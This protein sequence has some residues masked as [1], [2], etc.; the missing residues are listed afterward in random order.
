MKIKLFLVLIIFLAFFPLVNV[1]AQGTGIVW[2]NLESEISNEIGLGERDLRLILASIIN[3]ILGFI[4]IISVMIILL[5]GFKWMVSGGNEDKATEA[6]GTLSSGL[7]GLIIVFSSW[8]L[9]KFAVNALYN[10]T[11]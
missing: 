6:K 9:A 11:Q 10:A 2:G 8:G 7:I 4:G 5:G 1:G 3:V